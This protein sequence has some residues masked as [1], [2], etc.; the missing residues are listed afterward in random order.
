[1]ILAYA[2]KMLCDGLYYFSLVSLFG[3]LLGQTAMLLHVPALMGAAAGASFFAGR[4]W[5]AKA[6]FAPLI[7]LGL[8]I[9]FSPTLTDGVLC[10]PPALYLIWYVWKRPLPPDYWSHHA[11]FLF[12][13]K[14]L[15]VALL[16]AAFA[17]S[18]DSFARWVA[19]YFGMF[20]VLSVL[21]LRMLRHD[22]ATI[23]RPR[24]QVVNAAA[25]AAV[26]AAGWLLSTDW[27]LRAL[28]AAGAF[29]F[30]YIIRPLMML[31]VYL[32]AG[33]AAL[34][35]KLFEGIEVD[36]ETLNFDLGSEL[37]QLRQEAEEGYAAHTRAD[38]GAFWDYLLILLAVGAAAA[39]AFFLFRAMAGRS[40]R[41]GGVAAVETREAL[42]QDAPRES[43]RLRDDRGRVRSAYRRFL[44]LCD[45]K[46]LKITEFQDSAQIRDEAGPF[47]PRPALSRL[48]EVY[49]RA[50]YSSAPVTPED[51]REARES[52]TEL[53]KG[54]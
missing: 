53:K 19:P 7:L 28:R 35:G 13:L 32:F 26:C 34:V 37:T 40:R 49:V 10:V 20:L 43:P 51:V 48:R 45:Q 33:V 24:F 23:S 8:L 36:P 31:A 11:G 54:S 38:L 50:R 52:Y 5:G 18:W 3:P 46:G 22:A 30:S 21:L 44:K 47:F 12:C 14:I 39:M 1:M 41:E 25:V 15:P 9:P 4:R 2:L 42:P 27:T 17:N 29:L 6:R 16:A